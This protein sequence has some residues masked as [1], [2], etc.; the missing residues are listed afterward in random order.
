MTLSCQRSVIGLNHIFESILEYLFNEDCYRFYVN[1]GNDKSHNFKLQSTNQL[2]FSTSDDISCISS[3][4]LI[5]WLQ[6]NISQTYY[7]A[8]AE[9]RLLACVISD[10]KLPESTEKQLIIFISIYTNI[11]RL[12]I[13]AK[14]DALTGLNNR[15]SFDDDLFYELSSNQHHIARRKN[16]EFL[17]LSSYLV[18]IDIDYFKRVND[19]FGHLIGDEV[20]LTLSQIIQQSFR[21]HDGVY[22]YGGEEFAI[23]LHNLS[24][25]DIMG[26]LEQFA[27]KVRQTKFPTVRHITISA[28]YTCL[29][30]SS[31]PDE[32]IDRADGALY[33]SKDNGRDQISCYETLI[34]EQK[35]QS[36]L[37]DTDI[38]LF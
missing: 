11:Y 8:L 7:P 35:L 27:H 1:S 10:N 13:D 16:D 5:G 23:I 26:V 22:R 15:R 30:L 14:V 19:Q 32:A 12:I 29:D 38:E 24:S 34:S 21:S 4:N 31:S 28:G 20:L 2:H 17:R 9:D 36:H 18:L 37:V 6:G 33:Y 3:F 25:I